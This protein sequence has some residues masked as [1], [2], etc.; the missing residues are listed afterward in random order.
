VNMTACRN[1]S[2]L[3]VIARYSLGLIMVLGY[4]IGHMRGWLPSVSLP[5][6]FAMEHGSGHPSSNP[7]QSVAQ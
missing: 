7:V 1:I 5:Y 2:V 4:Y 3:V 6:R